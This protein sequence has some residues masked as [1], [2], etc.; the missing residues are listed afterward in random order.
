MQ[1]TIKDIKNLLIDHSQPQRKI[2]SLR[3]VILILCASL[4]FFNV[5]AMVIS[6]LIYGIVTFF[7]VLKDYIL[8][9]NYQNLVEQQIPPSKEV[10]GIKKSGITQRWKFPNP[11]APT[12]VQLCVEAIG[13]FFRGPRVFLAVRKKSDFLK[14][15]L[16][17]HTP[18]ESILTPGT[19]RKTLA[20]AKVKLLELQRAQKL[21]SWHTKLLSLCDDPKRV[22]E[23]KQEQ[24]P[25]PLSSWVYVGGLEGPLGDRVEAYHMAQ[26]QGRLHIPNDLPNGVYLVPKQYRTQ[27]TLLK[28]LKLIQDI[29]LSNGEKLDALKGLI[30]PAG[31]SGQEIGFLYNAH[32]LTPYDLAYLIKVGWSKEEIMSLIL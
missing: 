28:H 12:K 31:F 19:M 7:Y 17:Q 29:S 16:M 26:V 15:V 25:Q 27:Q 11:T 9:R 10:L 20:K 13:D 1:Y 24:K 22:W 14:R 23:W 5:W 4:L 8:E 32:G 2:D 6:F 18:P 3:V 21:E 30:E